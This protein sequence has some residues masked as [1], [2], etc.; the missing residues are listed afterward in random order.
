MNNKIY[1]PPTA[2]G[3]LPL[4]E[5]PAVDTLSNYVDR[6]VILAKIAPKPRPA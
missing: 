4:G 1:P 3:I 5:E 6:G 2:A